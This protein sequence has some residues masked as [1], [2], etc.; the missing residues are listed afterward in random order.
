[1]LSSVRWLE[2]RIFKRNTL[3]I[4]HLLVVVQC[5]CFRILFCPQR[6]MVVVVVDVV[7]VVVVGGGGFFLLFLGGEM[8]EGAN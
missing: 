7:V 8:G 1:M 5:K 4:K 2:L 3:H 6:C